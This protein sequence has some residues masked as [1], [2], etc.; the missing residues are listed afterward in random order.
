MPREARYRAIARELADRIRSGDL[1]PGS[2]LPTEPELAE[3]YGV[4][5]LTARQAMVE[6]RT[7]GL[8]ET[9]HGSGS[10]VRALRR[11]YEVSVDP[12]TRLHPP[13]VIDDIA[14]RL[15]G[16][17]EIRSAALRQ[18]PVVAGRLG[19]PDAEVFEV[20]TL[21]RMEGVPCVASR[22]ALPPRLA[23]LTVEPTEGVLGALRRLGLD[24]RYR[25]H[26]VSADLAGPEDQEL[27]GSEPGAAVLVR[28]GLLVADEE[29][30][31]Q[32]VRRCRGDLVAFTTRYE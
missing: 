27:L 7:G 10:Y 13:A 12:E 17:E 32:V 29:P 22:Y 19:L 2:R 9:R 11:R 26:T 6:L 3:H 28:E 8:V 23:D 16:G 1:A 5:R 24:H 20:A 18:D 25:S 15:S 4:H 21:L 31:C 30:L 14:A